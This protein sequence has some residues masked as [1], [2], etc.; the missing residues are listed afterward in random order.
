TN[1]TCSVQTAA[2]CATAGG[3]WGGAGTACTG[4]CSGACCFPDGTC[5]VVT[6][7]SC[8]L[9]SGATYFGNS[10][11][12]SAGPCRAITFQTLPLTYNWNGMVSDASEQGET[13][14]LD[15][16]GYRSISD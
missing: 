10:T 2:A 3:V 11:T 16:A 15:D 8:V 7:L 12:C 6:G 9:S 4:S 13:N 14:R 5:S 1:E